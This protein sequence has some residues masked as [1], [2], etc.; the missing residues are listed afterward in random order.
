[1]AILST[2]VRSV[3]AQVVKDIIGG[4]FDAQDGNGLVVENGDVIQITMEVI[5]TEGGLEV[6]QTRADN[7]TQTQ[8]NSGTPVTVTE[9]TQG[10]TDRQESDRRNSG[11]QTQTQEEETKAKNENERRTSNSGG[12]T[13]TQDRDIRPYP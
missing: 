10:S 2:N 7:L 1:M 8:T 13:T 6:T 5:K 11:G 12:D 3:T 4:T 9:D